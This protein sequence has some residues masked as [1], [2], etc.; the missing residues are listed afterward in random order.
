[1]KGS[2]IILVLRGIGG[3]G[4]VQ[5]PAEAGK[6]KKKDTLQRQFLRF[7]SQGLRKCFSDEHGTFVNYL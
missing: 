2:S 4:D 1:M 6:R 7:M 5:K 3:H